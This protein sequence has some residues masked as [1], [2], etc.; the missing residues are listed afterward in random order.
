M[1][2]RQ[3]SWKI[4]SRFISAAY[5]IERKGKSGWYCRYFMIMMPSLQVLEVSFPEK[6]GHGI[7][8]FHM[9]GEN[10]SGDSKVD[11]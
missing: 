10:I 1:L 6:Q 9:A 11:C 8:H 7:C 3:W 4:F 2:G 5:S